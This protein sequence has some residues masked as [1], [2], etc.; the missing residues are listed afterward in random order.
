[1]RIRNQEHFV[2]L[3]RNAVDPEE[4]MSEVRE[5][6]RPLGP[7]VEIFPDDKI[8]VHEITSYEL[9]KVDVASFEEAEELEERISKEI[10]SSFHHERTVNFGKIA[11]HGIINTKRHAIYV[12][13]TKTSDADFR[14]ERR[15]AINQIPWILGEDCPSSDGFEFRMRIGTVSSPTVNPVAIIKALQQKIPDSLEFKKGKIKTLE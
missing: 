5:A 4:W 12:P 8:R 14:E 6:A 7:C 13:V 1:M 9:D 3:Y 11:F 2:G 10:H 15:S